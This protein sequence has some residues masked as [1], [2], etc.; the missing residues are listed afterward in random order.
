MS[1]KINNTTNITDVTYNGTSYTQLYLENGSTKTC[2]WAKPYTLTYTVTNRAYMASEPVVH[3]TAGPLVS[4]GEEGIEDLASGS[5]IY[6]GD[7][8]ITYASTIPS[9]TSYSPTDA[10]S[11]ANMP[12]VMIDSDAA[13]TQEIS[14]DNANSYTVTPIKQNYDTCATTIGTIGTIKT[15]STVS[16][17]L[18]TPIVVGSIIVIIGSNM[19]IDAGTGRF[20]D[21]TNTAPTAFQI[22]INYKTGVL[23]VTH[24]SVLAITS[25]IVSVKYSYSRSPTS[26]TTLGTLGANSEV[27]ESVSSNGTGYSYKF[28]T[29]KIATTKT[30]SITPAYGTVYQITSPITVNFVATENTSTSSTTIY[31]ANSPIYCSLGNVSATPYLLQTYYNVVTVQNRNSTSVLL[32]YSWNNSDWYTTTLLAAPSTSSASSVYLAANTTSGKFYCYI[33]K[34]D[35]GVYRVTSPITQ[36]GG[37]ALKPPEVKS[38]GFYTPYYW[39]QIYNPNSIAVTLQW[40]DSDGE[41]GSVSLSASGVTKIYNYEY[42]DVT[43]TFCFKANISNLIVGIINSIY[44]YSV[45]TKYTIPAAEDTTTS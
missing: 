19:Y 26:T 27:V 34:S 42:Y 14:V 31:S 45:P 11:I 41:T 38:S 13:S 40:T 3:R 6:H 43:Y 33:Y 32:Y 35:T 39:V 10:D 29:N 20:V 7:Y 28:Q 37:I 25:T 16:S 1:L 21:R 4:I 18:I 24:T 12:G 22:Y 30:Y 8:L 23:T 15:G 17:T 5:T 9:S 36:H 2:Y 44:A